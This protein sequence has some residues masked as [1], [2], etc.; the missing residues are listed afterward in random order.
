MTLIQR[1]LL[2]VWHPASQMSDYQ[3]FPPIE[4]V[5]AEGSYLFDASGRPIID[6][7]SSWWCKSLGHRHPAITQALI[8][9]AQQFE[10]VIGANTCV[11]PVVELAER[12][13]TLSPGLNKVFFAS[14]G[15]SAV[16]ISMKLAIHTQLLREKPQKTQFISLEQGYHGETLGTLSVSDCGIYKK[17]Y[18]RVLWPSNAI[19]GIPYVS[20]VEDPLWNDSAS[21]WPAIEAQLLTQIE[22][23]AAIIVEPILQ[24]A[25]GMQIYSPDF[26]RRLAEFAKQHETLLIADEIMTGFG[27]TGLP[28]ASHHAM[29]QPDLICLGKG[30]T[31]GYLP[32]S[33]VLIHENI[34]EQFFG[35]FNPMTSFFHSHTHSNNALA[36][37]VACAALKEYES[38]KIYEKVQT[39]AP[40]MRELM[41][42]VADETGALENIRGIGAVVA[43]DLINPNQIPRLGFQVFQQ[44]LKLGAWLRPIGNTIY[45]LPPLN[46]SK[47]TLEEL[48]GITSLAMKKV[49]L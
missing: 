9:Q 16:E 32:M 26:L 37:A 25:A 28:L 34:Y 18:E 44:A 6:A 43:A 42:N 17:P 24:G 15:S 35:E 11:A 10:H 31:A 23:T 8:E 46:V 30:L 45:W 47:D 13:S 29:I 48:A 7:I 27:R 20:G 19:T 39:L 40:F 33:A 5:K 49:N 21:H 41:Q 2:H 36:A 1:D 3:D 38:S 22:K 4:I 14:D 12:L